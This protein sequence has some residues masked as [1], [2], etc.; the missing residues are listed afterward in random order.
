MIVGLCF[1]CSQ[2]KN[3]GSGLV[4]LSMPCTCTCMC[5]TFVMS[6]VVADFV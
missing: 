6:V 1:K 2:L 5:S 3:F 4:S